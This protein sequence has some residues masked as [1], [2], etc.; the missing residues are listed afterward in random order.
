VLTV[1]RKLLLQL[2]NLL[3]N[4]SWGSGMMEVKSYIGEFLLAFVL[5]VGSARIGTWM[6]ENKVIAVAIGITVFLTCF[7]VFEHKLP[8]WNEE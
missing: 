6:S 5:G 4:P 1:E 7:Y 8:K 2:P 3:L